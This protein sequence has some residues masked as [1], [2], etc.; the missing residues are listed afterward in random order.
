MLFAVC[1]IKML[2]SRFRILIW[3]YPWHEK[4]VKKAKNGRKNRDK[5]LQ[6]LLPLHW[7]S[8]RSLSGNV[9]TAWSGEGRTVC[10]PIRSCIFSLQLDLIHSPFPTNTHHS[11]CGFQELDRQPTHVQLSRPVSRGRAG[12]TAT[13]CTYVNRGVSFSNRGC[14]KTDYKLWFKIYVCV[15]A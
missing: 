3:L 14:D 9:G 12:K 15:R 1:L 11:K 13:R 8:T 2:L 4:T 6:Q 10:K 5:Q 7:H